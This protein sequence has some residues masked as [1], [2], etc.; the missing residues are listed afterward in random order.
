MNKTISPSTA[1]SIATRVYDIRK[2]KGF[3]GGV[4]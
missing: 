4:S 3:E 1:A 2:S